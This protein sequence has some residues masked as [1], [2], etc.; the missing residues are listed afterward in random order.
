MP[1]SPYKFSSKSTNRFKSYYGVP[2]YPHQKFKRPPFWNSWSYE[3]KK[4]DIEV[5][6]NGNTCLPSF[7]K[8]HRSVQKLLV[9]DTQRQAGDLINHFHFFESRL[10]TATDCLC[11]VG[12]LFTLPQQ[13]WHRHVLAGSDSFKVCRL[14]LCR[15]RVAVVF[16]VDCE[17]A[18]WK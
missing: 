6:L 10:K 3:I 9:G 1:S 18:R 2:L 13:A 5:I 8:I 17:H 15:C 12:R 11:C 16:V 14:S 4:C 7:T